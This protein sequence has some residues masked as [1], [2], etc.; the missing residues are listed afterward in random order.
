MRR[1][2]SRLTVLLIA[3]LTVGGSIVITPPR[4]PALA[5]D[6]LAEARAHKAALERQL[7]DQRAKLAQLKTTSAQ[8]ASQLDLAEAELAQVTAEYQRVLGLL[9]QVR[10]Q[11]AE[12]KAHLAELRAQIAALDDELRAVALDIAEQNGELAAREALLQDHMR[13]AYERT[14]ISLLEV[15]LSAE[16]LDTA[17]SQVGYLLTVS[18]QDKALAAEI[19][20]IRE[21]LVIKKETLADGRAALSEA[22]NIA[23]AEERLLVDR[24]AELEELERQT[25]ELKA[26]AEQKQAEQEA[27]LNAALDAQGNVAAQIAANERAF[28]AANQL[29]NQLVAEQ[30]ALAEARRR[31]A[32]EARNRGGQISAR[33]FAWP[34]A[35]FVITQE[36]GPSNF[37]MEP[38]YTYRGTYY[39]HFHGG[40]D[41]AG[42]CGTPILAA[43]T[44]VVVASGRPLWPWDP[45]YGV[46]I[47]HGGGV[48]TWYWHMSTNLIVN[49]GQPVTVGQRLGYEGS[50]GFSTGCHLHF[51]VNDQGV[52]ENPRFY[53]P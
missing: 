27:A 18:E 46:I 13:S 31:A 35:S 32:E 30:A 47:D 34:E 26:A 17:T 25:A 52:W 20:V 5:A 36:W 33:G 51:A 12:I 45:G 41:I 28:T 53:L 37:W 43:G 2:S 24:Q 40:I 10:V 11:V 50:T 29:V 38:P 42:G 1:R 9:E 22:R 44:G 3:L 49:R 6:P 48:Q 23:S 4:D 15:L 19:R 14:Q 8:L 21:Q 7:A 39:P 16:S